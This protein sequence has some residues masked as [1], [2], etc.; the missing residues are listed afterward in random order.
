M[1]L[2]KYWKNSVLFLKLNDIKES[3]SQNLN[4]PELK[5]K[6]IGQK[7]N[8]LFLLYSRSDLSKLR[9]TKFIEYYK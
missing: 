9:N 3:K 6:L 4:I 7:K 5:E 8:E 1:N 2:L